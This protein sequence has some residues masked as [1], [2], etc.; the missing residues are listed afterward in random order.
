MNIVIVNAHWSNRGDEA[1][2]RALWEE[3]KLSY[4]GCR[5][6]VMFKD[7]K[8][9]SWFPDM[10]NTAFFS[11]QFKAASWDIWLTVLTGGRIGKNTILKK[12]VST[13]KTADL[14][15]YPPGGSVINDRFFWSKQMEYLVPFLCARLYRIPIFVAAPS[16][17][18]F[19][20]PR[21]IRTWLLKTPKILCV[22]EA[23]S[24]R[25][26]ETIGIRDNVHVTMDLAFMNDV[27]A[28]TNQRK[29][30]EGYPEL[31][32]FL[33][34]H[35]KTVGMT[36]SDFKWHVKHGKNPELLQRI[37]DA[38]HRMI[39]RL[40]EEG[41]GVLLIP[42]LFGNQNDTDYLKTFVDNDHTLVM[43]DEPD[44]YFQQHVISKLYAVVG[45]RY[46]C[47]IFAAKMGVPFVAVAYEEKMNGFL[48]MAGL[49]EYGMNL[50]EVTFEGLWE[51]FQ[52]LESHHNE[53][54]K[55]IIDHRNGWREKARRTVEL[56]L[57][58]YIKGR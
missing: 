54:R 31:H 51:K 37:E 26:L 58:N 34:A 40:T 39:D 32:R 44:T 55:I 56:L 8:L 6:T 23:I 2:H 53:I 19:D 42:Q 35:P 10:K 7:R 20:K 5:I 49:S 30:E 12:A 48:E 15:I 43:S 57:E 14:I 28:K 41:V 1:A 16:M 50:E 25:Y 52:A 11:C 29:L 17:G 47:N 38:F 46:H 18:P 24:K 33:E 45:M 21:R 13:L 9:V 36:I 4:P 3:L 22:R 27:D